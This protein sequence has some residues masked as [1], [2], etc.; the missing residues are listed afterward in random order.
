MVFNH[1]CVQLNIIV[2]SV[3]FLFQFSIYRCKKVFPASIHS[4]FYRG[5]K[6]RKFCLISI[7]DSSMPRWF[8]SLT[9][10]GG[11]A[12]VQD[13]VGIDG[14]YSGGTSLV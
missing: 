3:S 5:N 1:E 9:W 14:S 10:N 2:I 4:H 13:S 11:I 6:N 12:V 8:H 7:S